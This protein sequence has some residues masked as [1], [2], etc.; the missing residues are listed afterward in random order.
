MRHDGVTTCL[1]ILALLTTGLGT[2]VR[3]EEASPAVQVDMSVLNAMQPAAGR[4]PYYPAPAKPV[5]T[6]TPPPVQQPEPPPTNAESQSQ[7]ARSNIISYPV[8]VRQRTELFDPSLEKA[9]TSSEE[10]FKKKAKPATVNPPLPPLMPVAIAARRATPKDVPVPARRPAVVEEA[11][12]IIAAVPLPTPTDLSKPGMA[13]PA[14]P[15]QR[16]DAEPLLAAVKAKSAGS[17]RLARQLVELDKQ[18]MVSSIEAVA[19]MADA[20]ASRLSSPV[21]PNATAPVNV[22]LPPQKPVIRNPIVEKI[23]RAVDITAVEPAAGVETA[24]LGRATDITE[25]AA[26]ESGHI[27]RTPPEEGY[28]QEYVSLTFPAGTSELAP[29]MAESLEKEVLA[30]L[31]RNPDWRVQIQ[32]FASNE[33]RALRGARRT[34]LSRALSIR[35]F[36]LGQGIEARRMDV[37]ALGMQTD[38]APADRVDFVFFDPKLSE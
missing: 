31:R 8:T 24:S 13:M 26:P 5:L 10:S 29:G 9:S 30:L 21:A 27:P 3:A 19:A 33:D 18:T 28:E 15:P 34:S 11:R 6:R 1:F 7:P 17:D 4:D 25:R 20:R 12:N 23:E 2:A 37:R 22:P 16:V 14:V 38:R 35:S 32:A 36:L